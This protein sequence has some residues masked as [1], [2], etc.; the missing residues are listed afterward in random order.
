MS[1]SL[2]TVFQIWESL[3]NIFSHVKFLRD[4]QYRSIGFSLS[5]FIGWAMG[6]SGASSL[7][8]TTPSPNVKI[9][10]LMTDDTMK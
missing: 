10:F 2:N 1:W 6:I 3:K 4:G 9:M 7:S 8:Y 5:F